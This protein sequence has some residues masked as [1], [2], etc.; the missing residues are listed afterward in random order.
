LSKANRDIRQDLANR[1]QTE[2]ELIEQVTSL[3][4]ERDDLK[5]LTSKGYSE[6][7]NEIDEAIARLSSILINK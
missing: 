4:L 7:Y 1:V 3:T 2:G 6:R 5:C